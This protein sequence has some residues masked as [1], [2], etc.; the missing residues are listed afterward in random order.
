LQLVNIIIIIIIINEIYIAQVATQL[1]NVAAI[2]LNLLPICCF[3]LFNVEFDTILLANFA[4]LLK[5]C[6]HSMHRVQT[7]YY[8]V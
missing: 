1:W 3:S 8:S 7:D 2:A 4:F 5:N 6:A